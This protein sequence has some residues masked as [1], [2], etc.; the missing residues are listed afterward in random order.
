MVALVYD[1]PLEKVSGH[2]VEPAHVR[3]TERLDRSHN[4]LNIVDFM[5]RSLD[6]ADTHLRRDS[7]EF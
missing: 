2:R 1:D 3:A 7:P 5:S 6:H 4:N